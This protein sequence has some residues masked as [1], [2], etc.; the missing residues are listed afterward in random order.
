[1]KEKKLFI[2]GNTRYAS[3]IK[4]YFQMF[5]EYEVVGFVVDA[6]YITEDVLDGLPVVAAEKILH[7]YCW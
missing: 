5:S 7:K 4:D 2:F 1:M 3:M 6:K